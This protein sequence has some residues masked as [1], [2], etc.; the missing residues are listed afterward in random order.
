MGISWWNKL[1]LACDQVS[2][3]VTQKVSHW[4]T[5]V[6]FSVRPL[7]P[8]YLVASGWPMKN[9]G[10]IVLLGCYTCLQELIW[11]CVRA[12]VCRVHVRARRVCVRAY[13]CVGRP[14]SEIREISFGGFPKN[15]YGFLSIKISRVMLWPFSPSS[16]DS[17]LVTSDS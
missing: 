3:W 15:R 8:Y 16:E 2:D 7:V 1:V 5:V 14:Q 4:V 12:C 13:V 6:R 10:V 9:A 11:V 17:L